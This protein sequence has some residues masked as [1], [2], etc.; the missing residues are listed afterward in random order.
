MTT[1][2]S[3]FG[4]VS[5]CAIDVL[6]RIKKNGPRN[7]SSEDWGFLACSAVW[8]VKLVRAGL[9]EG[10]S[11]DGPDLFPWDIDAARTLARNACANHGQ[12]PIK[13]RALACDADLTLS[14]SNVKLA[15]IGN[16][17]RFFEIVREEAEC[18]INRLRTEG[19]TEYA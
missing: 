18:E 5:R 15:P 7:L 3:L 2:F 13:F 17:I 4:D 11:F 8:L 10:V 14:S 9:G 16:A 19:D 6:D 12:D 1:T